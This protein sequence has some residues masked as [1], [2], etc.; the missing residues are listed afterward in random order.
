LMGCKR[1]NANASKKAMA[2]STLKVA[3]K[4]MSLIVAMVAL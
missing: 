4:P 2:V 1:R 3:E